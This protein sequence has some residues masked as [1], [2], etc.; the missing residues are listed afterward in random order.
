MQYRIERR[1]GVAA[2]Q[3]IIEQTKRALRTGAL[4]VGDRL[5]TAR[6]AAIACAVNPNTTLKAYREL[7]REGIVELRQGLGT[8]IT[9]APERH[10]AEAGSP[11]HAELSAWTERALLAGLSHDD[12]RE[13][14][15]LTLEEHEVAGAARIQRGTEARHTEERHT[16]ARH[17]EAQRTQ[18]QHTQAQRTQAQHTQA[19]RTEERQTEERK[20][21]HR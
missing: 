3:Q 20:G 9:R 16:D 19:P 2:Y 18:A 17:T 11:L 15:E 13:L 4:K 10:M 1:R 14:V 5:P 6:E 21:D 7:E 12:V 8:F